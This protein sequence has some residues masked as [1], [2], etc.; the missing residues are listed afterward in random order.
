[1][2]KRITND[3]INYFILLVVIIIIGLTC[4]G[5]S[6]FW[7]GG[8]STDSSVFQ[9]MGKK[10]IEGKVLYKDIFDH[11]GPIMYIINAIG[12]LINKDY[13][14]CYIEILLIYVSSIFI[15]KTARNYIKPWWSIVVCIVYIM[16]LF[17][18]ISNGNLTEEYACIFSAIGLYYIVKVFKN[19]DQKQKC[20]WI[21]I[22]LTF[23]LTLFLK[24]TYISLWISFAIVQLIVFIKNKKF[25]ELLSALLYALLGFAII[26]VPIMIYF[27][28]TNSV[29]DFFY[30]YII[31]NTKYSNST[32]SEKLLSFM[33][34]INNGYNVM[35]IIISIGILVVLLNKK[36]NTSVKSFA[37]LFFIITIILTGI[38]PNQY[39]HY[40]TQLA[41]MVAFEVLL[42][43]YTIINIE[44]WLINSKLL[45]KERINK[46]FQNVIGP[47]TGY[48]AAITLCCL[49][50]INMYK[51]GSTV[52]NFEQVIDQL[53][54]KEEMLEIT[55]NITEE[56]FEFLVIGNNCYTY[57]II[58]K[59]P[60]F[61]YF[62][63]YPVVKYDENII[64]E[65]IQYI[66]TNKPKLILL[67]GV[68][69]MDSGII[70]T[71]ELLN[72]L[73]ENYKYFNEK[74]MEY[75]ILK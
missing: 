10:L 43:I 49:T 64:K 56:D 1:M 48:I 44:E 38:A 14:I 28:V 60:K 40:L 2:K 57:L 26:A 58:D 46:Q 8:Q 35:L 13:G 72:V 11:K 27:I 74:G 73:K 15:Y 41:T 62:F 9:I 24:P 67:S 22:G 45:K 3:Y 55:S 30:A 63:Q 52:F 12:I 23:A 18:P 69:R 21:M 66:K 71:E 33:C 17:V 39:L 51:R 20:S 61:K 70:Y 25:K 34:L 50:F 54:S 37:V 53:K 42:I 29:Y 6:P 4:L 36:I 59:Y 65:T 16:F 32:I 19:Y 75:F 68:L 31:M 47:L 5:A 7:Q